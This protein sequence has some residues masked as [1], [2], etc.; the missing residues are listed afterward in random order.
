MRWLL[1]RYLPDWGPIALRFALG[2]VFMAHGWAKL[3]GP[4][5]TSEGF[6]IERWGWAYPVLWAWLVALVEFFGGLLVIVGLFTRIA[7]ALIACVM[8]VAIL[9]LKLSRGFVGG[10]EFEFALLMMALSLVLTGGGRV[11]VDRD[12]L[13]WGVPAAEAGGSAAEEETLG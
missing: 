10:F 6:N 7:A 13:G 5:G 2:T 1:R 12:V 4:V 8:L 9:K 11:S 3:S